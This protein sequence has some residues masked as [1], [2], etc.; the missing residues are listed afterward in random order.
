MRCSNLW[1]HGD[2]ETTSG[3]LYEEEEEEEEDYIMA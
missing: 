1:Q 3:F 2:W